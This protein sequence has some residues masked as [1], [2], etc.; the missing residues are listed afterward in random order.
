M[1]RWLAPFRGLCWFVPTNPLRP[2]V[3][4]SLSLPRVRLSL[5]SDRTNRAAWRPNKQNPDPLPCK[6]RRKS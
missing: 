1:R 4:C 2:G 6:N 3:F 5:L